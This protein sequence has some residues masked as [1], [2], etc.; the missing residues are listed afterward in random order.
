MA[1]SAAQVP[2]VP[3]LTRP[4]VVQLDKNAKNKVTFADVAGCDEAK[5][6]CCWLG[7]TVLPCLTRALTS[8]VAASWVGWFKPCSR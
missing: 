4:Q 2:A 1:V 7:A 3:P 8:L 5:V 6:G